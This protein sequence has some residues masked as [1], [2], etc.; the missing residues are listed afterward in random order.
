MVV[1]IIALVVFGILSIF[2]AT[3]RPLAK[4][5][6]DCVFRKITLRPCNTGL[7]KRLKAIAS[8]KAM[9]YNKTAGKFINKHFETISMALT[10]IMIA[11]FFYGAYGIYNFILY[12]NCNGQDSTAACY[13]NPETYISNGW[14]DWIFPKNKNPENLK[15]VKTEGLPTIG[16]E[17]AKI[18][19][20]EVGCFTCPYTKAAEPIVEEM[21]DKYKDKIS[22][23][24]KY[25]PIPSHPYSFDAAIAAECGREQG[26]FWELKKLLFENQES[27]S[28][29]QDTKQLKEHYYIYAEKAGLNIESFKQCLESKK[30]NSF[31]EKQKQESIEAGIYATPTFYI[32]DKAIVSPKTKEEIFKIIDEE[33]AKT[34]Q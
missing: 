34:N 4:E 16:N 29:L 10:I 26:K 21:L 19:I 12:G 22:F 8:I 3:H 7:D 11:S 17:N 13:L 2:S 5:A 15:P 23:S 30:Y 20:V 6:F 14:F 33:L 9:K 27:C 25:L 24:F 28:N 32:N 18:K 31:I 1:C